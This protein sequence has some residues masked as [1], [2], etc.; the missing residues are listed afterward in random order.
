MI[1]A[2]LAISYMSHIID[3]GSIQIVE[4]LVQLLE[5]IPEI[6]CRNQLSFWKAFFTKL[7]QEDDDHKE[8]KL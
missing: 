1:F 3:S 5:G 6:S 7:G 4:I 8:Q 2:E